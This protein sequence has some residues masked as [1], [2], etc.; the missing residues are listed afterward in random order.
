MLPVADGQ[1]RYLAGIILT[2]KHL[3]ILRARTRA[4]RAFDI[5]RQISGRGEEGR[6]D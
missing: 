5:F 2:G 3:R 6:R 1:S 4:F